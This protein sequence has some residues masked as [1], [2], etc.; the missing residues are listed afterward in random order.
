M[1]FWKSLPKSFFLAIFSIVKDSNIKHQ[2]NNNSFD[3]INNLST[4]NNRDN[5][6][7]VKDLNF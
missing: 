4:D 7:K 6:F 3:I 5:F 1:C 2:V